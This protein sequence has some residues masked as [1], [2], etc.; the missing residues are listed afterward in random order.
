MRKKLRAP[1]ALAAAIV[2]T[3]SMVTPASANLSAFAPCG[4]DEST[5][6][7]QPEHRRDAKYHH[8]GDHTVSVQIQVDLATQPDYTFCTQR[9]LTPHW[10]YLG[11]ANAVNHAWYTGRLC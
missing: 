5:P 11:S 4:Y 8:C 3:A 7:G 2:A 10:Y 1:V 6:V 9:I